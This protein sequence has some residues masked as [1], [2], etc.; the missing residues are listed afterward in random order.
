MAPRAPKKKVGWGVLGCAGIA[1]KR[2]IPAILRANNAQLIGV[3]DYKPAISQSIAK[4]FGCKTYPTLA[5]LLAD[6]A[7]DAIYIATPVFLHEEHVK[8]AAAAGVH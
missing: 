3:A 1:Q 8:A 7:I 5:E 4:K 2:T 6:D